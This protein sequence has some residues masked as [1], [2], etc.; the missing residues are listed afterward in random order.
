MR[1]RNCEGY[2]DPTAGMAM[3]RVM[4]EY[5]ESRKTNSGAYVKVTV[6][7]EQTTVVPLK[8]GNC[9]GVK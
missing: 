3:S 1:Y 6:R 5:R 8:R 4:K 2:S 7:C 9:E